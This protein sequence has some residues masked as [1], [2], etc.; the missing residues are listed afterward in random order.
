MALNRSRRGPSPKVP[1]ELSDIQALRL[2][3]C[4]MILIA[5][6][7]AILAGCL[8]ANTLRF[9]A[10]FAMPG[11]NFFAVV[12]PIYVGIA[13]NSDAYAVDVLP[14]PSAGFSRAALAYMFS[15]LAVLFLAFYM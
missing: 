10:P 14:D 11:M 13:I 9:G 3:L 1:V 4:F 12:L 2:R 6:F 7:F 15:V 5:D 8:I